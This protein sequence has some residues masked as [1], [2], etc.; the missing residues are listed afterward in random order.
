MN[1]NGKVSHE[2]RR[3]WERAKEAKRQELAITVITV[4]VSNE[5]DNEKVQC[6][7]FYYVVTVK[8]GNRIH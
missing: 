6:V 8:H 7:L 5:N 4:T 1:K 2:N 3:E